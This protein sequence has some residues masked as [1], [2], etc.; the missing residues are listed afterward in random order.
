M[1]LMIFMAVMWWMSVVGFSRATMR[2]MS[3]KLN[4]NGTNRS[5]DLTLKLNEKRNEK[6]NKHVQET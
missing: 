6:R 5:R 2:N 1:N 3:Q 4:E